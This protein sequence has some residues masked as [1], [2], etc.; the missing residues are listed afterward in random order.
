M[1]KG[2]RL[3]VQSMLQK[4]M[5]HLL[6]C[7]QCLKDTVLQYNLC[8][9]TYVTF[10]YL[11]SMSKVDRLTIQSMLQKHMSHLFIYNQCLKETVLQYNLCYRNICHI[12]LYIIN[13]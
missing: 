8:Y 2:D 5:S 6:I 9:K 11:L 12:Y 4:H 3:T 13:I 1:S 10:I 7:N